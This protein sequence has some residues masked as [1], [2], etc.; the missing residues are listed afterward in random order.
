MALFIKDIFYLEVP[1]IP[2]MKEKKFLD[3]PQNG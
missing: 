1:C 3:N 2:G